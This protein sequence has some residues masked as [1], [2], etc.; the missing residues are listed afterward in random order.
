MDKEIFKKAVE[1]DKRIN[2]IKTDL[3]SLKVALESL[4]EKSSTFLYT[5]FNV[6]L[7]LSILKSTL[8][9]HETNLESELSTL[10]NKFKNL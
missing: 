10:E 2:Q 8:K 5:F 4:K 7:P 9:T 6:K 3:D 1:T